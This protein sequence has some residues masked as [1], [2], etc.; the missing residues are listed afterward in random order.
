MS[1]EP[2]P[3][4]E[5]DPEPAE[6]AGEA[7]DLNKAVRESKLFRETAKANQELRDR[8]AAIEQSQADAKKAEEQA[9]LEAKGEYDKIVEQLKADREEEK[10]RYERK[11]VEFKLE[12]ELAKAG[13]QNQFTIDGIVAK[14]EG[15]AE[16]VSQYVE[17]L[18]ADEANAGL[19]Q[20]ARPAGQ[21]PA[22]HSLPGARS[23]STDLSQL[24]AD[25]HGT[26]PKKSAAAARQLE[27]IVAKDGGLP[28]GW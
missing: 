9:K 6:G 17:S 16:E 8:L 5:Q 11:E 12:S 20:A 26:D 18:K 4:P 1:E 13:V 15:S 19:F 7:A 2:T 22:A 24:K 3:K 27:A 23:K 14:F 25:L 10:K 21:T 28:E